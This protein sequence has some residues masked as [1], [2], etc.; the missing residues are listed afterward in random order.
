MGADTFA[1]YYGV[2]YVIRSQEELD[3]LERRADP[4]QIAARKAHLQTRWG[5]PTDGQDFFLLIGCEVG[6]FGLENKMDAVLPSE[7]MDRLVRNTKA[8]LKEAGFDDEPLFIFQV[9]AQY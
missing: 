6:M 3:L 4:R 7:A 8:K 1:V 9:E 2:R 5:R